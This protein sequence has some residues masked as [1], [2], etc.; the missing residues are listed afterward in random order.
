MVRLQLADMRAHWDTLK[1]DIESLRE[2]I[3]A[4]W[5]SEDIYAA[6]VNETAFLY[7]SP[8]GFCII[9]PVT[10]TFTLERYMHIWIA[11][12]T[13]DRITGEELT[14]LYQ[15][16]FDRIA[17]SNGYRRYTFESPRRGW[18]KRLDRL[19]GWRQKTITYERVLEL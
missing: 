19:A 6:C 9:Q 4:S 12:S 3:G 16:E 15:P 17:R 7:L 14:S 18:L 11:I 13:S 2:K 10:D 1:P 8:E 5:R